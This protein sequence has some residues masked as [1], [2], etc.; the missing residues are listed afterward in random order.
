MEDVKEH[1]KYQ[2]SKLRL[3]T[4]SILVLMEDVK[5]QV[6]IEGKKEKKH[7]FQSLF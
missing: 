7:L 1:T 4:V 6:E 2:V 5:E 3:K